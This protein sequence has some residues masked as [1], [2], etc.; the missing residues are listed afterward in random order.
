[1]VVDKG[2]SFPCTPEAVYDGDGPVWCKEGPR[3]RISGIAAREMNGECRSN[4][5]CPTATAEESRDALVKLFG[6]ATGPQWSTKHIPVAGKTMQCTSEGQA[7]GSRTGAW[8]KLA[9]G[10]DLSCA[11]VETGTVLKW[12][13]YWKD[14]R[15]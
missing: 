5:P 3:L 15:C 7:V 11:M 10:R 4:Q 9:D 1:V 14:H 8:C 2:E 12:D 6:G 13:R